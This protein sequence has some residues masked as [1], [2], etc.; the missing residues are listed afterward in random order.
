MRAL[1]R[2]DVLSCAHHA[3]RARSKDTPDYRALSNLIQIQ[4]LENGGE[5]A[6]GE[7]PACSHSLLLHL[8]V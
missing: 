3:P 4:S 6:S 5:A 1:L 8:R 7:S 2:L